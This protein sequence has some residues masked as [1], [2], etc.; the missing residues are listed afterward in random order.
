MKDDVVNFFCIFTAILALVYSLENQRRLYDHALE[1]QAQQFCAN[2]ADF[3][4]LLPPGITLG[5]DA[6]KAG[7]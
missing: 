4:D 5:G 7:K 1:F 6:R 2:K 3:Q